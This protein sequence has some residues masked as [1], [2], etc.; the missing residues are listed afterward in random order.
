ASSIYN[1][2]EVYYTTGNYELAEK[3]YKEAL[4]IKSEIFKGPHPEIADILNEL[5]LLKLDQGNYDD[6]EKMLK[7]ALEMRITLFGFNHPDIANNI[8]DLGNIQWKLGNYTKAESL[9]RVTINIQRELYGIESLQLATAKNNLANVLMTMGRYKETEQLFLE[10]LKIRKEILGENDLLVANSLNNLASLFWEKGNYAAAE[11]IFEQALAIKKLKLGSRHPGLWIT[12]SN[13]AGVYW[14]QGKYAQ[15]EVCLNECLKIL[16]SNSGKYN[17]NFALVLNNLSTLY[18][19]E[20]RYSEADSLQKEALLIVKNTLGSGHMLTGTLLK[21]Y[22]ITLT[23]LGKLSEAEKYIQDAIQIY[24]VIMHKKHPLIA[25]SYNNLGAIRTLQCKYSSA[26]STL[27]K[28]AY[29]YKMNF[30]GYH[31][32]YVQTLSMLGDVLINQG[33]YQEA[34]KV[35][36]E[37]AQIFE[38]TRRLISSKQLTKAIYSGAESPYPLFAYV[39]LKL[40]EKDDVWRCLE[41]DRAKTLLEMLRSKSARKLTHQEYEKEREL[42]NKLF[43]IENAI[44]LLSKNPQKN[45]SKIDSIKIELLKAE[46]NWLKFQD[47]IAAK[48]PISEGRL[49]SL[50]D[51]QS[52]LE[53]E[54][55]IIGWLDV[56]DEHLVYLLTFDGAVKIFSLPHSP[57]DSIS[58][59]YRK[60]LS[61]RNTSIEQ[62]RE[63]SNQIYSTRLKPLRNIIKNYK[64]LYFILSG[65][66]IGIPIETIVS[67]DGDYFLQNY[68]VVYIPS[69]SV[70]TWIRRL[71]K[72]NP[73]PYLFALADPPFCKLHAKQIQNELKSSEFNVLKATKESF[74]ILNEVF[75][76][77]RSSIK[78]LSRLQNTKAEVLS[79]SKLFKHSM[80]LTGKDASEQ[81]VVELAEQGKL[82]KFSFIHLATH[83]V[84]DL[85]QWENSYL[86]LSQ[87]DLPDP[88]SRATS[89]KR[90][91][92]GLLTVEEILKE[93]NINGSL[94]TLSACETALGMKVRN[95]GYIGFAQALFIAGARSVVLSLWKVDDRATMLL[96]NRFY[97]NIIKKG[98]SKSYAIREAKL[99]LK[100]YTAKN[101][102]K[103]YEHPFYWAGFI[104]MG[105]GN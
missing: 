104:L 70:L 105:D 58:D 72:T 87:V 20:E 62:V 63:I 5:G 11:P 81:R 8:N 46:S 6:S 10:S 40:G 35:L 14:K 85:R 25:N 65:P 39:H 45:A 76:G 21:N 92:D 96:M 42:R 28:A 69:A 82:S 93:W 37:A 77:K 33:K 59:N 13:L 78:K 84:P 26:E 27:Q 51:I 31:P 100:D 32:D 4:T 43:S 50:E 47:R 49:F 91:I 86:V 18:M 44:T 9:F 2:A 61:N 16:E 30:D 56:K 99:W 36:K 52:S 64:H 89:G 97:R 38:K 88:L 68:D 80:I 22:A 48:H 12:L 90:I 54:E 24:Q 98:Y 73:T 19:K 15:A 17:P 79:I 29:I 53:K 57:L 7:N 102:E 67:D 95:E 83:A 66:T 71:S 103:P 23:K 94:V 74:N 41:K 55:A 60:M 3:L 1:L 75:R 101:G 34:K